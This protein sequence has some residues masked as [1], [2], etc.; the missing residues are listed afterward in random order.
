M[1]TPL[2]RHHPDAASTKVAIIGMHC[3]SCVR[4]VE[5]AIGAVRGVASA[6]VSLPGERADVVVAPSADRAKVLAEVDAAIVSSGFA[7]PDRALEI[8][9][10]GMHCGS[11]VRRVEQAIGAVPGV[12]RAAVNLATEHAHVEAAGWLD[13]A[14][15]EAAI[16]K[17]GFSTVRSNAETADGAQDLRKADDAARLRR[18]LVIAVVATVPV[19]VLE[20]G[21]HIVPAF[22]A[23]IIRSFG[24]FAPQV[25]AFAL[26]SLVLFGPDR[27]PLR[28]FPLTRQYQLR[29]PG[30]DPSRDTETRNYPARALLIAALSDLRLGLPADWPAHTS[31]AGVQSYTLRIDLQRDNLP[32]ALRLPA[33]ID[34]DWRLSTGNFTWAATPNAG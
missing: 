16:A 10:E 12:R 7:V 26:T 31:S 23:A 28:Y 20:M 9:I 27:K 25:L 13:P 32:G 4:R 19:L 21:G 6:I 22:H 34:P 30:D 2:A 14:A 3:A 8:A 11:C 18:D 33:L 15:V 5:Q 29:D 24:T 1:N 17:A